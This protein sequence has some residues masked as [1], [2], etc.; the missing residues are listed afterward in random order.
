MTQTG[1]NPMKSINYHSRLFV[2]L[3]ALSLLTACGQT[4]EPGSPEHVVQSLYKAAAD[5]GIPKD[6]AALSRYFDGRLTELL[7]KD[8]TC[9]NNGESCGLLDFDPISQ[10][11]N[12]DINDLEI[13]KN[14]DGTEVLVKFTQREAEYNAICVMVLTRDGWRISDLIYFGA[15]SILEPPGSLLTSLSLQQKPPAP[16]HP[17]VPGIPEEMFH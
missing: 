2:A 6:E 8:F 10:S 16:W 17:P 9:V 14:E 11:K 15:D 7:I 3:I 5:T 12:P 13:I 1:S 4:F